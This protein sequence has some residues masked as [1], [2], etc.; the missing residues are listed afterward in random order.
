MNSG[1]TTKISAGLACG[2]TWTLCSGLNIGDVVLCPSGRNTY[3]VGSISSA[4]V[5]AGN[6]NLP[7]RR[8]VKWMGIEISPNQISEELLK[9]AR[10]IG[11]TPLLDTYAT[12]IEQLING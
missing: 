6:K 1:Y 8:A 11:T 2:M 5:Y 3:F 7:H 4:Y 10:S 9:S 12:E